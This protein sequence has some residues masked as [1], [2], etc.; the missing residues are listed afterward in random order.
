MIQV[1]IT[2]LE[3]VK[4]IIA[5][6]ERDI[7]IETNTPV[8]LQVVQLSQGKV[9]LDMLLTYV[10]NW[11]GYTDRQLKDRSRKRELVDVRRIYSMLANDLLAMPF[12]YIGESLDRHH[13]SIMNLYYGGHRLLDVKDDVF[14]SKYWPVYRAFNLDFQNNNI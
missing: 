10:A 11:F 5:K 8:R 7:E 12:T 13:T 6:A 9:G 2:Q 4:K 14:V 3:S 1:S